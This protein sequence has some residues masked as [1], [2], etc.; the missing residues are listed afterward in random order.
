MYQLLA[1]TPGFPHGVLD[2]VEEI[3]ALGLKYD[4][5][6]HVDACLG[7]FVVAFMEEAGYSLPPF[8]FRVKGVTSI[9]AD[10][11]KVFVNDSSFVCTVRSLHS[12]SNM[13]LAFKTRLQ[14][15]YA[16]KGT[17][18]I[19][20]SEPKYRHQQFFVATEWPGGIYASPTLAGSRPGG[21]VLVF[22]SPFE[23]LL[24]CQTTF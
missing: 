5:P 13:F 12:Y 11:H 1:S 17:S 10:T 21:D 16:P 2:P 18:L 8:D 4:I 15:G 20:Y 14:Y 7:G 24:T 3:A 23:R 22:F 6:V 9:S 19:M